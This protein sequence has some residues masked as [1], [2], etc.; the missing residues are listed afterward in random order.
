MRKSLARQSPNYRLLFRALFRNIDLDKNL[1]FFNKGR[2]AMIYGLKLLNIAPGS[3][4]L[5]PAYICDA[6]IEPLR[7][8]G[9]K[10]VFV[11]IQ[12]DLNLNLKYVEDMIVSLDVTAVLAVHY[13]G[14]AADMRNLK[15]LCDVHNVK[16]IEDCAH[17]FLTKIDDIQIGSIGHITIYSMRKT[18]AVPD[19]GALKINIDS[20]STDSKIHDK[21]PIGQDLKYLVQR[22][23]EWI[24]VFIANVNIYSKYFD[25]LRSISA[26]LLGGI[27]K[28]NS[29]HMI[30]NPINPS[31][32]LKV[33]LSNEEY[34]KE[35]S[36]QRIKNYR[37]VSEKL[38][39]TNLDVFS[40]DI[41][42]N[43][44]PQNF[45]CIDKSGGLCEKFR[46]NGLGA[47][48]WPANELPLLVRN[49]PRQ[50]PITN[51]LNSKLVMLPCHQ[52]IGFEQINHMIKVVQS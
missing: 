33:Y 8:H 25:R 23:S 14:F 5:V 44:V 39:A 19:G 3:V 35:I 15:K 28:V 32:Q 26:S 51:D 13:F 1:L 10:P 18:L 52:N 4:I 48:R 6:T 41:P 12:E 31:W 24:F 16:I 30:G 50:F 37:A 38:S 46:S 20:F 40:K 36:T 43:C 21:A 9:Y 2:D 42:N 29:N 27:T 34:L 45:I 11:D 7:Q 49:N 17:S 22:L 47:I